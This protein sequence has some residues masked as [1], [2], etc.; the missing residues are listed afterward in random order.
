MCDCLTIREMA[1]TVEMSDTCTS[2]AAEVL[3]DV[4]DGRV[5]AGGWAR[6]RY[7]G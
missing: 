4:Y 6:T 1:E 2:K 5:F 7:S 3:N